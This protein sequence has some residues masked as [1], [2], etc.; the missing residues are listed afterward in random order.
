MAWVSGFISLANH[1]THY[2]THVQ[3]K[4]V[5]IVTVTEEDVFE[6]NLDETTIILAKACPGSGAECATVEVLWGVITI[7][8]QKGKDDVGIEF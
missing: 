5:D 7:T 6:A 1:K 4:E 2:S 3:K 8:V